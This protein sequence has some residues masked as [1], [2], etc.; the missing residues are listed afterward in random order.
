MSIGNKAMEVHCVAKALFQQM[1]DWVSFFREMLG[2][3]GVVRTAFPDLQALSQFELTEEYADIQQMM[4]QLRTKD[5]PPPEEPTRVITIRLPQS[6]HE[7]LRAEAYD[8][9]TSMNKLC[10]SK[11]LQ[12]I[13]GDLVPTEKPAATTEKTAADPASGDGRIGVAEAE[14]GR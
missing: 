9:H 3:N 11:L 7:A 14:I 8:H 1:P 13:D 10:I 5:L 6:V 12:L 4:A 2:I